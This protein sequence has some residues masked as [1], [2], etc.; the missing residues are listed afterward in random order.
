[1]FIHVL[2]PGLTQQNRLQKFA[3]FNSRDYHSLIKFEINALSKKDNKDSALSNSG[4]K[5]QML[6]HLCIGW[7][8][9]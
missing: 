4:H 3:D 6:I 1:M 7:D 8:S 2:E 9:D 5:H